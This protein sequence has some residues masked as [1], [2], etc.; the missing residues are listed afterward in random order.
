[1]PYSTC[2][3]ALLIVTILATPLAALAQTPALPPA[4]TPAPPPPPPQDPPPPPGW[5]G[6]FGAG[7]AITQGNSDT[8]TVNLAYDVK[9]DVGSPFLFR[10]AGLFIR[11]DSEGELT[12][13]RLA[14]DGRVD[15]LITDRTS[16]FGQVQYLRDE[17]KEID[18]LVSPTA[19][20]AH[21]LFRSER[22]ELGVDAGAGM[23]WEKNPG[24]EV[25]TDGAVVA[26]QNYRFQI[27][28]NSTFTQRVSA[29][30]KM[31]DFDDGLYIF[32]AGLAAN[33]TAQTQIKFELLNTFKNKPPTPEVQKN[34][35][36]ILLSFVYKY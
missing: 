4:Q 35:I 24:F 29:L 25:K 3:A 8:S 16:I 6:S 18:Y 7:M 28:D 15:R 5:T 11:A 32:G 36:A 30:W 17:F 13:N 19:G 1:M 26:G 20:L 10:S 34:D 23:V 33:I 21:V 31:D 27:T 14:F 2:R 9:R 12:T 22:S